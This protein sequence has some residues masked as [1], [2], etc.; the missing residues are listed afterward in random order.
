MSLELLEK[1]E[2]TKSKFDYEFKRSQKYNIK[3]EDWLEI[4]FKKGQKFL[5]KIIIIIKR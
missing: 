4:R 2:L 5:I 1:Y 3:I